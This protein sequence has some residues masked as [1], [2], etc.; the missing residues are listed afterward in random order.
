MNFIPSYKNSFRILKG[1]K[2]SLVVSSFLASTTLTFAAPSG[3]TVTSGSANI[4]QNGKVTDITQSTQKA[5][6]NWNKFNIASDETV[7]FKQ[8]NSS[9]ITLN[10]VVGNEKSI[11][12]GA[13]NANGQVWIINSNGVLFGKGAS[14]NT[15]GLLATTKDISDADF[16]AGNYKFTGNSKESVINLGTIDVVNGGSVILA[17]NEVRNEGT[18]KAIKGKIH[19]VGANEYSVNLNGNSLVNLTVNKGVLDALVQNSGTIIANGGE[20]YLTTNAVNELLKG[21]VNNTGVIEANSLAGI[22]GH[23]ELF[24]H[25]GTANVAGTINATDGFVETSGD[26]VKIDDSFK[27]KADKW[28]IDPTDFTIAASGGDISGATLSNT[29]AGANV[30]IQS[31]SGA[32]GTKGDINVNDTIT[33]SSDKKLTLNAQNDIF[34]NKEITSSHANGKLEL[35]YGQKAVAAGN[36]S[37]YHV[38]AKVNLKAGQNFITKKGSDGTATDWIVVNASNMNSAMNTDKTKSYVLGEDITLSGTNNWTSIGTLSAKFKGKFD[39]LGH[40][41]SNLSIIDNSSDYIGLF[42]HTEYATIQNIGLV[43][44]DIKG[45]DY[46]GGLAGKHLGIIRNSYITGSIEG[47]QY[48]GGLVGLNGT[49]SVPGYIKN[50]YANATVKGTKF[51]GGLAGNANE[52][53]IDYSYASGSVTGTEEVYGLSRN[54]QNNITKSFYDKEANTAIMSDSA[55][56]GRTK[57]EILDAFSGKEAWL[58]GGARDEGYT[59]IELTLPALKTFNTSVTTLFAGGFGTVNDAYTITNWNQLQNINYAWFTKNKNYKLLNNISS[60]T[61]GYMG[62]GEG[63]NPIGTFSGNFDGLGHSISDLYINRPFNRQ[64]L[65]GQTEDASIVNVNLINVNITGNN[66]VGALVG[67]A[68]ETHIENVSSSG[69]VVGEE[70]V[71][72]L[73]GY[74]TDSAITVLKSHSSA[75]VTGIE[76]VGG[77][78]GQLDNSAIRESYSTGKV[79]GI[80]TSKNIGGLVG[81]SLYSTIENSYATGEVSGATNVGGLVGR[82]TSSSVTKSFWDTQTSGQATSAVGVGKTTA[83]MQD[84]STF[85]GWDIQEDSTIAKG[86]PFLAWQTAGNSYTKTWVIGTKGATPPTPNPV[87]PKPQDTNKGVERIVR[88]IANQTATT[89]NLPNMETSTTPNNS[90]RNTNISFS[91]GENQML[92]SRPIEG[93]ATKRVSL[94]EARQMQIQNGGS[95]EEVI[96]PLSNSSIIQL[97]DGG[98]NL[99]SGVEQEFYL[100]NAN[101]QEGK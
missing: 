7:N 2:I 36:T 93:Q 21:V 56:Y 52:G 90:G 91:Q 40:T 54:I 78:V 11:I 26:K 19:L 97:V 57:A 83:Q 25:G 10:R 67:S 66:E 59:L 69:K 74:M 16:Q 6:I 96:V 95:G 100:A 35:L 41:I 9:S 12:N 72:G 37:D 86:T 63:W 68:I 76:N 3:G 50:S 1:G 8:P 88:S 53:G 62:T 79:T 29:L 48:V 101:T 46:V 33:W 84:K 99:P 30:E 44:V 24:A 14:I 89:V 60:T 58:V 80:G 94:S 18:I 82:N 92:V 22:T 42:G 28:L 43:N 81:M 27:V 98:V 65:F 31:V 71:G 73:V 70:E 61:A 87:D 5:S 64:S 75:E 45:K 55:T 4:S 15:S 23:V 32:K 13:L 85:D 34:I 39:G 51:V 17:A 38:N 49:I 77:L 47:T 20:I